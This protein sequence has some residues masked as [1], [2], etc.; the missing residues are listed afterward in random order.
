MFWE[1]IYQLAARGTTILVTTHYM[2]EAE[3]CQ[4]LAFLSRGHLIALGTP[5]MVAKTLIVPGRVPPFAPLRPDLAPHET[6]SLDTEPALPIAAQRTRLVFRLDPL[7]GFEPFLGA[8]GHLLI[9]SG[10]RQDLI[11]THPF[12]AYPERGHLQFN[13]IF[14]R[15]GVHRVWLQVQQ[16]GQ[17]RTV[18]F[19]VPVKRLS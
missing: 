9:A 10:D 8:W 19:D 13:V 17:V 4:R 2:D 1:T 15:P 14:P 18:H 6:L 7:D 5:Q 16:S 11:H 12:L 3:R